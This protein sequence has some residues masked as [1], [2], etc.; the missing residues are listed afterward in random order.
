MRVVIDMQG[1]Q[2]GSRFR[3]IGRYSLSFAQA[4]VRNRGEHEIFLTLSALLPESIELIRYAFADIL[5]QENIRVWSGV[6]PVAEINEANHKNR[7]QSELLREAFICSLNPDLI[8]ICSLFEGYGDNAVTSVGLFDKNTPVSVTLYDLIPLLNPEQYLDNDVN[9]KKYYL[10]KVEHLKRCSVYLSISE[11]SKNE[12]LDAKIITESATVFPVYGGVSDFFKVQVISDYEKEILNEKLS[13]KRPFVLFSGATDERKNIPRLLEAWS[14]LPQK[15]RNTYQIVLAGGLPNEHLEKFRTIAQKYGIQ[16]YEI[17]FTGYVT[18]DVFVKL[19]NM[20]TLYIFPSWHE[21]LG[22]PAMEAMACGA[23]VV[24]ANTSSLPEVI[25]LDEALFDPFDVVAISLAI[26]K[27]IIDEDYRQRLREHGLEQIKKFTWDK[28]A[29]MTFDAWKKVLEYGSKDDCLTRNQ[30]NKRLLLELVNLDKKR[31]VELAGTIAK[32]QSMSLERQLFIDISCLYSELYSADEITIKLNFIKPIIGKHYNDYIPELVLLKEDNNY[33]YSRSVTKIINIELED[34][35]DEPI[36]WQRGDVFI[37]LIAD[38]SHLLNNINIYEYLEKNGVRVWI[39]RSNCFTHEYNSPINTID[40]N[41]IDLFEFNKI[42]TRLISSQV[43]DKK[44][45]STDKQKLVSQSD[46]SIKNNEV[47]L[48]YFISGALRTILNDMP[49]ECNYLFVDISELVKK[50]ART[51]IQRVVRNILQE[52]LNG[53]P[54]GYQVMPVYA[55]EENDYCHARRFT[56][57][58]LGHPDQFLI[59]E[60]IDYMT[61]DIFFYT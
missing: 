33:Y 50:D 14:L 11:F 9:Y 25:G 2:S 24:G 46:E 56:A 47:G 39:I 36:L 18:D 27:G 58:F 16:P 32:N 38:F 40:Q 48:N 42:R 26:K 23:P 30:N 7:L 51:G 1:A 3:G 6:E 54:K 29:R 10:N 49:R 52:W 43:D 21:G 4:I 31:L 15:M 20:C 8:H 57:K 5:P 53:P 34:E 45:Y 35:A 60:P 61:G 55:T 17:C 22:L 28:T 44:I 19:Y 41:E 12:A 59:D 13:I 37:L